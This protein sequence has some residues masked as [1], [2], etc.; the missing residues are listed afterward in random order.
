MNQGAIGFKIKFFSDKDECAI[1]NG[2]CEHE[3]VNTIGSYSCT[4][5]NGYVLHTN[6]RG[7]KEAGCKH[8]IKTAVGEITSPNWPNKC[9]S[10]KECT[11]LIRT[12]PGHRVKVVLHE[13]E[14]ETQPECAYDHLELYDGSDSDQ[15]VLGRYCGSKKPGT[16]VA[17]TSIMFIKFFSDA[18]V[19]KRVFSATHQT[20]KFDLYK[21]FPKY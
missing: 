7:C 16:I 21:H 5:R 9:P 19:Q 20:G 12:T 8:D 15:T 4:C 13:F 3:C 11:W 14:L 6:K 17:T 1:S 2:G 18:S 10:R